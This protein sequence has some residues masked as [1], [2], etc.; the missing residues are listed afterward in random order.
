[1]SALLV[2]IEGPDCVGKTTV[3]RAVYVE[4]M[5]RAVPAAWMRHAGTGVSAAW[6]RALHFAAC[7]SR[8]IDRAAWGDVQVLLVDRWLPSAVARAA[9]TGDSATAALCAAEGLAIARTGVRVLT[10]VLTAPAEALD[11]RA[12]LR[13]EVRTE[14]ERAEAELY[15]SA[16]WVAGVGGEAVDASGPVEAVVGAVVERVMREVGS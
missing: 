2:A 5:K 14:L 3:A 7:R 1:M 8:F 6:A 12:A 11:A 10:L 16:L 15:A 9:V 13:G 4:L